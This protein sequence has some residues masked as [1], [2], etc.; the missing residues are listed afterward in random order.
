M[1]AAN[2]EWRAENDQLGRFIEDC[3]VLLDCARAKARK[4]YER[5]REWAEGSGEGTMTETMF[6]IR[7]KAKGFKKDDTRV[8]IEY[9]GIGLRS[10]LE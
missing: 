6:C 9:C 5:Y 8:G 10:E 3:C 4:L 2:E 1:S 7:L